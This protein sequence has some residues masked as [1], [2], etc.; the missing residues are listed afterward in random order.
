MSLPFALIRDCRSTEKQVNFAA[1]AVVKDRV[2]KRG[3]ESRSDR[4]VK[5]NLNIHQAASRP[6]KRKTESNC[7]RKP[8]RCRVFQR[9]RSR[10][11]WADKPAVQPAIRLG[12]EAENRAASKH[13]QLNGE[14]QSG[15]G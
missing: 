5:K 4:N 8:R 15:D 1:K 3:R 11:R 2:Q 14:E 13:Q 10:Q 12:L 7:L 9:F 6:D